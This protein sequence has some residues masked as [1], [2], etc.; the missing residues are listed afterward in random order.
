MP[1]NSYYDSTGWP[2]S[3]TRVKVASATLRA[4]FDLI[5]S[6]FTALE[7][8]ITP[9]QSKVDGIETNA[10]ADQTAAEILTLTKTVD[11]SGSGLDADLLD[12]QHGAYYAPK[13]SPTFTT[14]A[15]LPTNTTFTGGVSYSN[16]AGL[17]QGAS[18]QDPDG[19]TVPV[20]I[21]NHANAPLG[22]GGANF[23]YITTRFYSAIGATG[24]RG[25][26]AQSYLSASP[27]LFIRHCYSGVWSSWVELA[28]S[29]TVV[30]TD[31]GASNVGSFCLVLNNGSTSTINPNGTVSGSNL[32]PAGIVNLPTVA[33]VNHATPLSGTWRACGYF[34][35][36]AA[37]KHVSLMQRIA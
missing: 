26:I 1:A 25:Q 9:L 35:N 27:R 2:Q 33:V 6:G 17:A 32:Y 7:A 36:T 37:N 18:D 23:F 10:T 8:A 30:S 22:G 11:G 29:S 3:G 12:G 34:P 21:T 20:I 4:E 16:L 13:D 14:S 28:P 15:T 19:A 5:E 31:N 24:N